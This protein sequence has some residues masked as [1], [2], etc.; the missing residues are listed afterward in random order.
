MCRNNENYISLLAQQTNHNFYILPQHP[1]NDLID[2]R[3]TNLYTLDR[4]SEPLD[5]LICYDNAEQYDE[6]QQLSNQFH[7][8]IIL[9]EFCCQAMIRQQ[10]ILEVLNPRDPIL[11][12]RNPALRVCNTSY[13][14]N[15]WPD[16]G[17]SIT[18]PIGVDTNKF[19]KS[20]DIDNHNM[21]CLDNNTTPQVGAAIAQQLGPSYQTI[22]TD[23][24]NLDD[25]SVNKSRYFVNT[26]K[27]ITTKTL[28]AMAAKNVVICLSTEDTEQFIKHNETGILIK[29]LS[30]LGPTVQTLDESHDLRD[31]IT[32]QAR[33]K[34][35]TDHSI[36]QFAAQWSLAF[37]MVRSIFYTL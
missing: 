32:T 30:E 16:N 2:H 18:I 37:E 19:N 5:Y 11:Y 34:I 14:L 8:P 10:N 29:D 15:S 17:L 23:H 1:W 36:E 12:Q 13:I 28:Q 35:V 6:A 20:N 26:N 21:V 4:F 3:P 9:I 22:P 27:T 7:I 33:N 25:I 24:Q 31:H